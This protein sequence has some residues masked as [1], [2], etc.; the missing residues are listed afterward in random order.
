MGISSA[1]LLPIVASRYAHAEDFFDTSIPELS[2][3]VDDYKLE[4][5]F[6]VEN[7]WI[8][9]KLIISG[10]SGTRLEVN[11]NGGVIAEGLVLPNN[12][13]IEIA[14]AEVMKRIPI[15]ITSALNIFVFAPSGRR[16]KVISF[17]VIRGTDG[18]QTDPAKNQNRSLQPLYAAIAEDLKAGKPLVISS[19]V[20]L[21]DADFTGEGCLTADENGTC[22]SKSVW[23][24]GDNFQSNL[25]W[26]WGGGVYRMFKQSPTWHLEQEQLQEDGSM[27]AVFSRT[28]T[29]NAVWRSMGVTAP[30]QT[31]AV[32]YGHKSA[33]IVNGYSAFAEDLFGNTEDRITL[34]DNRQISA[35]GSSRIVG[36]IGHLFYKGEQA[37]IEA[38]RRIEREKGVFI[39]S[40]LSAPSFSDY[41]I[42]ENSYGLL[43][44]TDYIAPEGYIFLPLFQGIIEG[45][46][47]QGLRDRVRANYQAFHP[48]ESIPNG[49]FVNSSVGLLPHLR[50]YEW[51]QDGDGMPNRVDP[52]PS[53]V[54]TQI[55]P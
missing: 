50:P 32:F 33:D 17:N 19:H 20:V 7:S 44:S 36:L 45:Q 13:K 29:P 48:R 49:F 30:F 3:Y 12:G 31:Y 53:V 35:G 34:P 22:L 24:Q 8:E 41:V 40:C 6:S 11:V 2:V 5:Y 42:Q 4:N 9:R 26:N 47:G 37:I 51:D 43:F 39:A 18:L 52:R 21:W 46:A 54:D 25:Y 10:P 15:G 28:V 23:A 1:F 55:A 27:R 16:T 14:F 38:S